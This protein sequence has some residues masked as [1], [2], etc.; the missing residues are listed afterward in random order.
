[1]TPLTIRFFY[2]SYVASCGVDYRAL[3]WFDSYLSDRQQQCIVNGE[4]SGSRA[5]TCGVPQGSLIGP[6]LF[7]IYINDLPNCL[8][9][10]LPRMYANDTSISIAASSLSELKLALNAE[11]ANL[12]EWLN[13]NKL[14]LNIAKTE[15]MLIGSRQRLATTI[16]HSLTVQIKGHEIDG[17]P[18][19]KSL[20][21]YIDQNLSWSKHVNETA[22]IV[23]FS[24]GIGALKRLRPFICEDTAILLYRALIESYFDYC[25]PVW[26]GLSKFFKFSFIRN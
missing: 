17:V 22:K 14:S 19:T 25:C 7:L 6:L 26:G 16:D 13:V 2:K 3:K 18:H 24:S 1:M 12:H 11:L 21:V 4:L 10:A 20:G 9:K 15:F 8:T 5:V 23:T